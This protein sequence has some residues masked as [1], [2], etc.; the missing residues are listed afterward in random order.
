MAVFSAVRSRI[1][2]RLQAMTIPP[3]RYHYKEN[4]NKFF[5]E[6]FNNN[7]VVAFGLCRG[8]VIYPN[9]KTAQTVLNKRR[10]SHNGRI[11]R[12]YNCPYCFA[13]HLTKAGLKNYE[14]TTNSKK[15]NRNIPRNRFRRL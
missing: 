11:M 2:Y 1:D 3:D 4:L 14:V 7:L 6:Q 9:K 15:W 8:K 10:F 5:M 13:W 12:I